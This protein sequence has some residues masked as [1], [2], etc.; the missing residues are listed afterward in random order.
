[1]GV[2]GQIFDAARGV[3][4]SERAILEIAPGLWDD[5]APQEYDGA[6]VNM[7]EFV[8]TGHAPEGY[9][10]GY[11]DQYIDLQADDNYTR[12]LQ[13]VEDNVSQRIEDS[14]E[15]QG[16]LSKD[17]WSR[18]DRVLWEKN[19]SNYLSE[20]HA[21]VQGL[22]SYRNNSSHDE[23]RYM[24]TTER[25]TRLNDLSSDMENG[26]QIIEHDC[27]SM[28]RFE[29]HV[30]Q[31]IDNKFLPEDAPDGDFKKSSNYFYALGNTNFQMGNNGGMH[32]YI[33]SSAT[34]NVIEATQVSGN[35]YKE[36]INPDMSFED[37]VGGEMIINNDGSI[38]SGRQHTLDDFTRVRFDRG[39]IS[40]DRIY[41]NVPDKRKI[42]EDSYD[43]APPEAQRLMDLKEKILQAEELRDAG[44]RPVTTDLDAQI[45]AL[46]KQFD[47][48][49]G[50][51]VDD[52]SIYEA[53]NFSARENTSPGWKPDVQALEPKIREV[54]PDW[55]DDQVYQK[56]FDIEVGTIPEMEQLGIRDYEEFRSLKAKEYFEQAN[57]GMDYEQAR[58]SYN[59]SAANN[60]ISA[61]YRGEK[62]RAELLA[63]P[64]TAEALAYTEAHR[65]VY[66]EFPKPGTARAYG[67]RPERVQEFMKEYTAFKLDV[68]CREI[69]APKT[70]LS[71]AI[72]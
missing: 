47:S 65:K 8:A 68:A 9:R 51:M 21:K 5:S 32:A 26:T 45:Q 30:L 27:E 50:D 60:D 28:S 20:A 53:M 39:E 38:Y 33:V 58:G 59:S 42:A 4:Y 29:G 43:K 56:M 64:D 12:A 2:L 55:T 37:F 11:L 15:M 40:T 71:Q 67:D 70:I 34:M 22:E 62:T 69:D 10:S 14:P 24:E 63:Q 13:T 18:Q 17:E 61:Y 52:S 16:L 49:V 72:P 7:Q 41:E 48:H 44:C 36:N 1:M 31:K 3:P 6:V 25:A 57:P 23:G 35:P 46:R 66:D 54:N 19:V